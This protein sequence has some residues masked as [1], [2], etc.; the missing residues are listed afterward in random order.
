MP[1]HVVN[2]PYLEHRPCIVSQVHDNL[3]DRTSFQ[4]LEEHR[5]PSDIE[6]AFDP[7]TK[8]EDINETIL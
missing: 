4:E 3:Q 1:H 5:K 7:F 8:P 2:A 6:P